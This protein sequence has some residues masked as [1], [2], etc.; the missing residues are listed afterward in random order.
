[1]TDT[2]TTSELITRSW[3]LSGVVSRDLETVSGDQLND[4]LQMLNAFLAIKTANQR[5]IPYYQELSFQTIIGEGKYFIDNLILAE[6]VAFVLEQVRYPMQL[7]GRHEFFGTARA[8]NVQ[9]LP[10]MYFIERCLNGSDLYLYFFPD[11]VY[12]FKIHGKFSLA[13]VALNQNLLLTL[14]QYYIEYL[15]YGLAEYMCQEYNITFQPQSQKRLDQLEAMIF[16]ISPL[17]FT[18]RKKSMLQRQSGPD[19]YGQVNIGKGWTRSS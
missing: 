14:D 3:Y 17:D 8:N 4:G 11:K 19:I 16:D 10:Y 1:M 2:Y 7:V 12:E 18:I 5:L 6:T 13:N 15:R 9:S